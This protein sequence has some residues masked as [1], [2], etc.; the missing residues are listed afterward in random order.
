MEFTKHHGEDPGCELRYRLSMCT[1]CSSICTGHAK[2]AKSSPNTSKPSKM[3][4]NNGSNYCLRIYHA[5]INCAAG[6]LLELVVEQSMV[7][8][9]MADGH[10]QLQ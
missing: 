10:F 7:I 5:N 8:K 2:Q 4:T 6:M 3:S 1:A 9:M